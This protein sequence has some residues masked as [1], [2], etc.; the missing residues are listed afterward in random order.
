MTPEQFDNLLVDQKNMIVAKIDCGSYSFVIDSL[1]IL[2]PMWGAAGYAYK[3][4][5]LCE[6]AIQH[7]PLDSRS[8]IIVEQFLELRKLFGRLLPPDHK[9]G[10]TEKYLKSQMGDMFAKFRRWAEVHRKTVHVDM[11]TGEII[12]YHHDYMTWASQS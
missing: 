2:A 8:D 9:Y 12:Y 1:R 5:E 10:F 4:V 11:E 6:R 7:L 3:G